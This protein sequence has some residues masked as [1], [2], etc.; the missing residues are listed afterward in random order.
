MQIQR[1]SSP[2][3]NSLLRQPLTSAEQVNYFTTP[4]PPPVA[5]MGDD[6]PNRTIHPDT[7]ATNNLTN[8]TNHMR[9]SHYYHRP[10]PISNTRSTG[11]LSAS[12]L[13]CTA[14]IA[15]GLVVAA[16]STL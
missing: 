15:I 12:I 3:T 11:C 10:I 2:T 1:S 14:G 5:R 6:H 16:C 7:L 13:P 9:Q 4:T 8:L